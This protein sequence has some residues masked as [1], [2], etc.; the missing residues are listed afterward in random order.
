MAHGFDDVAGSG[1]ALG[2]DHGSALGDAAQG[3]P[4]VAGSAHERHGVV[5][6]V[7][8]E[9]V[10]G[11]GQHFAFVD[12]VDAEGFEDTGFDDVADARLGHD[13]D[14]HGVHDAE[15][16]GRIGHA[17][18]APGLADIGGDA[19]KRHDGARARFL[20]DFCLFG[21]GDVH[22]DAA[23]QHFGQAGLELERSFFHDLSP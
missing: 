14:G 6:L 16:D 13:R 15:D 4:E 22:D 3:F 7:D 1:L 20:C 10:V 11:G 19:L 18:D 2:T 21:G 12:V 5:A 8:M 9:A 17:G 23:L